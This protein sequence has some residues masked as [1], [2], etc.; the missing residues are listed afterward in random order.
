MITPTSTIMRAAVRDP[1]GPFNILTF[2]HEVATHEIW[3]KTPNTFYVLRHPTIN[4]KFDQ[5]KPPQ[6]H[7]LLPI[8]AQIRKMP[9]IAD[10]DLIISQSRNTDEFKTC[11]GIA[12]FYH[13]PLL[14]IE[15]EDNKTGLMGPDI[16]RGNVNVFRTEPI[17]A[18][19]HAFD[20]R[21]SMILDTDKDTPVDWH[22]LFKKV[23]KVIFKGNNKL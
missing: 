17:R 22:N 14:A 1:D 21:N 4:W 10:I 19:W 9:T 8:D 20:E 6:N 7:I 23:A 16:V 15:F 2:P 3:G 11:Y 12:Q 5:G 13:L 18:S